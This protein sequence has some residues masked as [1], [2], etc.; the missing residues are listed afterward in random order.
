LIGEDHGSAVVRFEIDFA[1]PGR[2]AA[3]IMALDVAT[4]EVLA[5]SAMRGK[6]FHEPEALTALE[7]PSADDLDKAL[8]ER[9]AALRAQAADRL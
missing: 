7:N 9:V 4:N 3:V 1:S 2:G 6:R 8:D 5:L